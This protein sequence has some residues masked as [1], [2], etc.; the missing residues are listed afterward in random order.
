LSG[1]LQEEQN[2]IIAKLINQNLYTLVTTM[3]R[4]LQ[5]A[6]PDKVDLIKSRFQEAL[7]Q[8]KEL[9]KVLGGQPL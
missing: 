1:E 8:D 4:I 3:F 5:A 7:T 9:L 6:V 2:E